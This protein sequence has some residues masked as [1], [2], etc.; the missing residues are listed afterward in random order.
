MDQEAGV[1][2]NS[3]Y[4]QVLACNPIQSGPD[5]FEHPRQTSWPIARPATAGKQVMH[6]RIVRRRAISCTSQRVVFSGECLADRP[7]VSPGSTSRS[8]ASDAV[9]AE[10]ERPR[11]GKETTLL[12]SGIT[13]WSS[14]TVTTGRIKGEV[15]RLLPTAWVR[16]ACH[17]RCR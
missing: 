14:C 3:G 8:D 9:H 4:R 6:L 7:L 15:T 10:D 13:S 12:G 5:Y 11:E 2:K 1:L 16:S 17:G